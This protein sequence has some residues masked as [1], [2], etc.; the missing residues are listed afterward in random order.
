MGRWEEKGV[1][2]VVGNGNE[3]KEEVVEMMGE[4]QTGAEARER[5]M[6]TT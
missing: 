5:S 6:K 2:T 3:G 4:I 1:E